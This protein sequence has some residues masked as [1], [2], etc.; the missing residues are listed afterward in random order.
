MKMVSSQYSVRV[1]IA[2][3]SNFAVARRYI[4]KSGLQKLQLCL[5]YQAST[6]KQGCK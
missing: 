4:N 2:E 3:T 1:S 6:A 5:L